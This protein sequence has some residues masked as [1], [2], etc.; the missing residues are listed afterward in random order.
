MT[1]REEIDDLRGRV[2]SLEDSRAALEAA[3]AEGV[4]IREEIADASP[5]LE[6]QLARFRGRIEQAGRTRLVLSTPR[7][8]PWKT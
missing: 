7:P 5:S 4:E 3:L 6:D 8:D 1:L 2:A